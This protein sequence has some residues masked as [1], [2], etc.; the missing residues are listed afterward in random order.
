M[1]QQDMFRAYVFD[2]D[3]NLRTLNTTIFLQKLNGDWDEVSTER[4]AFIRTNLLEFGYFNEID[5]YKSMINFRKENDDLFVKQILESTRASSWQDFVECVNNA[6]IFAWN[7]ARGHSRS[8]FKKAAKEMILSNFDGL[9]YIS[10]IK[11]QRA[12]MDF[13][14]IDNSS[15]TNEE[16]LDY[17]INICRFYGMEND[18]SAMEVLGVK[19]CH[20]PGVFKPK[21]FEVFCEYV[22]Q[23]FEKILSNMHVENR[24]TFLERG[25]HIG[26]S[27]DDSRTVNILLTSI[28]NRER[29]NINLKIHVYDTSN[30]KKKVF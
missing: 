6:S 10:L 20:D 29:K 23:E 24:M 13:L 8:A 9:D 21:A 5:Y 3:N 19:E 1:K 14:D 4:F 22:K 2:I 27:D 26:I 25:M 30:G 16:I 18:E 28:L 7:T 11:N 12:Y 17:Y 15:L